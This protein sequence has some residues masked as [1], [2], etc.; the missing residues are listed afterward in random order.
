VLDDAA[1][2][3]NGPTG[4]LTEAL[5]GQGGSAASPTGGVYG[6]INPMTT[7]LSNFTTITG[8][9]ILTTELILGQRTG[10]S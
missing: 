1:T 5:Y 10:Q 6:T 3:A 2:A 4:Y 9:L 7:A 8:G